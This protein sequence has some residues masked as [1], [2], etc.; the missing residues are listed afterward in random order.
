MENRFAGVNGV[1]R[2]ECFPNNW[3]D[4]ERGIDRFFKRKAI[5]P[6]DLGYSGVRNPKP[7]MIPGNVET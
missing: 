6:F 4:Q 7:P 1:D 3:K 5:E 2:M